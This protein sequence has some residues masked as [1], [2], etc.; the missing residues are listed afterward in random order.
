MAVV[1]GTNSGFVTVSP[2]VDPAGT[3]TVIDGLILVT[4]D[5]SPS[6][7]ANIT[8]VGWWCDTASQAANY[9]VGLYAADG[10][11]VPGEAGTLL[12]SSTTNAKGTTAGWKKVTGLNWAISPSTNYW[13]AVQLDDVTT[14]TNTN[15]LN[16]SGSGTDKVTGATLANPLGGGALTDADAMFTI[17]AVWGAATSNIKSYNTNVKS[18]I[19]SINTNVIA[20]VK[21]LNTNP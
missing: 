11:T 21:T 14:L 20:N 10:A 2:T 13:I 6:T 3:N 7:A 18:N 9:E 8:E 17:Y 12:F 19:K 16:N 1:L 15:F 5:V 4:Q